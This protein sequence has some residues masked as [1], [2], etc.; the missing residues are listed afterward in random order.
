MGKHIVF[1]EK[2][3]YFFDGEKLHKRDLCLDT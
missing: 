1:R 2:D 3:G